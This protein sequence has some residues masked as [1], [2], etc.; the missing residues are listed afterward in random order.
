M[1]TASVGRAH[2]RTE[3]DTPLATALD[4]KFLGRVCNQFVRWRCV[5]RPATFLVR[6]AFETQIIRGSKKKIHATVY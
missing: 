1:L 6:L 3:V 4:G 2:L 5:Y